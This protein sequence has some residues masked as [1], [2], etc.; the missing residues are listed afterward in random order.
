MTT[1]EQHIEVAIV[2][3][4]NIFCKDGI[5]GVSPDD[6]GLRGFA[7]LCNM[8]RMCIGCPGNS[9]CQRNCNDGSLT[10]EDWAATYRY[11]A[12]RAK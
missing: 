6:V 12:G 1:P 8:Y 9:L 11:H 2:A 3:L 5:F 7:L 10:H 4:Y